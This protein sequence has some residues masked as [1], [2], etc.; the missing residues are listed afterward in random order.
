M[1]SSKSNE[2]VKYTKSLHLKKSRDEH[3]EFIV[4]G[5]K[6]VQEAIEFGMSIRKI[7]ICDE[8][9]NEK[10]DT[11]NIDVEH[12]S[13]NVFEY[14]SDTKTPQGILAIVEKK[15]MSKIGYGN[16][17]FA[18]EDIQDPGNL[19]TII[20]TLDCAG[21]NT[22]ILSKGCV[23][24]YNLKVIRSTMGAIFRV[25]IFDDLLLDSELRRLKEDGYEIIVTDLDGAISLFECK[26][27]SKVVV[28]IG[29]EANGISDEIKR[30]ACKRIKIPMSGGTESLNAGVAASIVAYE[31]YRRAI[32]K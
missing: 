31:I 8:L 17:I 25:N 4:E 5:K 1:I 28:V 6:M 9:F 15:D 30:I 22:L 32:E 23:D 13:Q 14:L 24:K 21:I 19:G 26:F 11:T 3:N 12:V 20:R 10:I 29:N 2:L 16:I 18:L 7:I 27:T